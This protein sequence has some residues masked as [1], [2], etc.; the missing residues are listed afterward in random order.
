M[1]TVYKWKEKLEIIEN[2]V[3][4]KNLKGNL[5]T[6]FSIHQFLR[7]IFE[8]VGVCGRS[9]ELACIKI[10]AVG[11]DSCKVFESNVNILLTG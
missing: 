10:G 6:Q 11:V 7:N 3:E 8:N 2:E 9:R 1:H 5:L 4:N